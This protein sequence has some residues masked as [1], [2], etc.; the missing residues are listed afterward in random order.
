MGRRPVRES[1]R[2]ARV[3]W[4]VAAAGWTCAVSRRARLVILMPLK[5]IEP[6]VVRVD[7]STGIVDVV[8]VY[9]GRRHAAGGGD[10][11]LS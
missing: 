5:R 1:A 10:A 11:I 2:S 4:W 3:A 7:N 6:F 9:D 8:P